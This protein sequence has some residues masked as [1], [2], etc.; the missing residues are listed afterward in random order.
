MKKLTCK[1]IG[2]PCDIELTG[3]TFEEI[4]KKSYAHVMEQI[5]NGDEA[6]KAAAAKMREASPEQQKAW[7]AEWEKN[8]NDA[9]EV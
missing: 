7:M 6:H 4:G 3:N 8:F 2:G 1:D 5:K 9:P